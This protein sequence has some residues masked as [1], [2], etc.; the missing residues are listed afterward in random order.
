[1]PSIAS[2]LYNDDAN[3]RNSCYECNENQSG[4]IKVRGREMRLECRKF[5]E[6][7]DMFETMATAQMSSIFEIGL[8]DIV[9]IGVDTA[10][11]SFGKH[12]E[13]KTQSRGGGGLDKYSCGVDYQIPELIKHEKLGHTERLY[14]HHKGCPSKL[15]STE[16]Q[17]MWYTNDTYSDTFNSNN[18]LTDML[19]AS[20]RLTVAQTIDHVDITGVFG[21]ANEKANQYDGILAQAYWAYT[22]MAYFHSGQFTIDE[23]VLVD[24]SFVHAKYA[25]LQSTLDVQYDSSQASDPSVNRFAT[26][27]EVY[28]AIVNWLND[29]VLTESGRKYVDATYN[30]NNIIL[31]SKWTEKEIELQMFVDTDAT[32]EN[33]L[34]CDN[35]AGVTYTTLQGAMPVDERPHLVEWHRYTPDNILQKLPEDI[36]LATRDI[37]LSLMPMNTQWGLFVDPYVWKMYQ[38]ARQQ[39]RADGIQS[40]LEDEFVIHQLP[41][42]GEYGGTGLWFITLVSDTPDLRNVAH[43][44]D[45]VRA[46]GDVD[47]IYVG[48]ADFKCR[49]ME[50]LYDVLHGVT[51][52]DFRLFASNL[53]CSPFVDTFKDKQPYDKTLPMLPCWNRKVRD[54]FLD[55]GAIEGDCKV[56]AQFEIT[57]EYQNSALYAIPVVGGFDIRV[58]ED[59]EVLPV[60]ALPVFE[61]Q[62][63]DTSV[64]IPASQLSEVEY[65]YIVTTSDGT[66]VIYTVKNPIIQYVGNAAGTAFNVQQTVT[67]PSVNCVSSYDASEGYPEDFPFRMAG[68]CNDLAVKIEGRIDKTNNYSITGANWIGTVNVTLEGGPDTIDLALS[69]NTAE[70]AATLINDYLTLNGFAGEAVGDNGTDTLIITNSVD[71]VFDD[72]DASVFTIEH[73]ITMLDST[74]YDTADGLSTIDIIVKCQGD[75]DPVSPTFEALPN[76][77]V[78]DSCAGLG[79]T[80]SVDLTTKL[81]CTFEGLTVNVAEVAGGEQSVSFELTA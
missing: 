42:L 47:S 12:F 68:A 18:E 69:G 60:G 5:T 13:F 81:G 24:G 38:F 2:D 71:V 15:I 54:S 80:V 41:A 14:V 74:V 10:R 67:I 49:E 61:I 3:L 53:L 28:Q 59:G 78:I 17:S 9:E 8:I 40:N 35:F 44:V 34:D 11:L 26:Y 23:S 20:A 62:I 52:K 76:L 32:V 73:L 46:N 79:W 77:E 6:K 37:D 16:L 36:Y 39:R 50:L 4:F 7:G 31:T 70:G 25:G 30:A 48:P 65:E 21:G 22:L 56:R 51:V 55:P 27:M 1:M 75:P 63:T 43:L 72:I 64:G 19:V 66:E 29:E 33:W 58:L 45:S 57:D